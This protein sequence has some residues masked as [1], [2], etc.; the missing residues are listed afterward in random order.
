MGIQR[1]KRMGQSVE[2]GSTKMQQFLIK[3]VFV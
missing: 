1:T 2:L 3:V